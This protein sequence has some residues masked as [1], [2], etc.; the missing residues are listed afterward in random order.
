MSRVPGLGLSCTIARLRF[1]IDLL[2]VYRL[3]YG[4]FIASVFERP[5]GL[6]ATQFR[7]CTRQVCG[8]WNSD[9]VMSPTTVCMLPRKEKKDSVKQYFENVEKKYIYR[10]EGVKT[11][12]WLVISLPSTFSSPWCSCV[13]IILFAMTEK[14]MSRILSVTSGSMPGYPLVSLVR[15]YV[16]S[17]VFG[18]RGLSDPLI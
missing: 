11:I 8:F 17:T 5:C 18:L 13:A 12:G 16:R 14:E 2:L 3:L 9:D 6:T 1:F 4:Y 15:P 7:I 10:W